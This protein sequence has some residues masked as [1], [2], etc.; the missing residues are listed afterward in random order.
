MQLAGKASEIWTA[1]LDRS[2]PPR[3]I[4]SS[5][6]NSP[7]FGPAE[8]ILFRFTD[9]KV[10]YLGRMNADGS[11]RRKVVDYAIGT[12]Q[13]ISPDRRWLVAITPRFDGAQGAASMAIPTA[14]GPPRRICAAVCRHAWSPDGRFLYVEI[15]RKSRTS[16]GRTI[17]LPVAPDTGLPDLPEAGIDPASQPLLIRGSRIVEL[18]EIAPGLDPDTYAYVKGNV[19]RNLFR[20]PRLPD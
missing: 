12:P 9:G 18:T 6:E 13:T 1:P 11:G 15:E 20:I 19:Q 10:N 17:V 3:A 5:G 2:A 8:E 7:Q 16:A 4:A 14:G